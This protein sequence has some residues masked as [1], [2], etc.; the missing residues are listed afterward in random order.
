MGFSGAMQALLEPGFLKPLRWVISKLA[1]LVQAAIR[2]ALSKNQLPRAHEFFSSLFG[3]ELLLYHWR[4]SVRCAISCT[5][6]IF[7]LSPV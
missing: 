5:D 2:F 6:S 3:L 1:F 7:L 4:D